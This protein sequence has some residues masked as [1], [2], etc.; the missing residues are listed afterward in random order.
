[1]LTTADADFAGSDWL[2]AVTVTVAGLGTE[3]GAVKRPAAETVPEA[4]F[5]PAMPFTA[6]VTAVLLAPV[7][8]AAN[9]AVWFVLTDAVSGEIRIEVGHPPQATRHTANTPVRKGAKTPLTRMLTL[10]RLGAVM[11][12]MNEWRISKSGW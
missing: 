4:L 2:V 10:L 9:M 12:M 8:N 7:T 1:M 6:H 11:T 5:P 3:E